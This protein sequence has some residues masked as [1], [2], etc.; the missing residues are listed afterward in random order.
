MKKKARFFAVL[1]FGC[2]LLLLAACGKK[3]TEK[4]YFE[5]IYRSANVTFEKQ[6]DAALEIHDGE[7]SNLRNY[8]K[9]WEEGDGW[10]RVDAEFVGDWLYRL[11]FNFN[12]P[13]AVTQENGTRVEV[14]VGPQL[15]RVG[16]RVYQCGNGLTHELLLEWL[17][18]QYSSHAA[19]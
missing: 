14:L 8:W 1:L 15:I 9:S 16:D 3:E 19:N 6:G 18:M 17:E 13:D 10:V 2:M 4:D 7:M 12:S 11:V 5:L